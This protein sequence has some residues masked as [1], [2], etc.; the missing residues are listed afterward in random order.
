MAAMT[1]KNQMV[2]AVLAAVLAV[3]AGTLLWFR[4]SPDQTTPKVLLGFAVCAAFVGGFAFLELRAYRRLAGEQRAMESETNV[5]LRAV[6][7]HLQF[8]FLEP[9]QW[10]DPKLDTGPFGEARGIYRGLRVRL[11]VESTMTDTLS[12]VLLLVRIAMDKSQLASLKPFVNRVRCDDAG[13]TLHL[14]RRPRFSSLTTLD[15]I[16]ETNVARIIAAL[17]HACSLA[18]QAGRAIT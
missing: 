10:R 1:T 12:T 18:G 17:D 6:A 15:G 7:E 14:E 9:V 13:V 2:I 3:T 5:A 4:G 16:P 11:S 8:E